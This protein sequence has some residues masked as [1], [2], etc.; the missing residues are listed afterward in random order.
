MERMLNDVEIRILGCLIEKENTTPEY[1]PLS[2][3]ALTNACNQKSNRN[4]V[5][6]FDEATVAD[7]I[8]KLHN[9]GFVLIASGTGQRVRKYLHKCKDK[10]FVNQAGI[11]IMCLLMLRGAQTL[12]ELRTRSERIYSFSSLEE[13]DETIAELTDR[14]YPLVVKL[15]R[16][17]GQ[18]RSILPEKTY[19]VTT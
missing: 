3:N 4:P 13:V 9:E 16:Q 5:V 2:L 6:N 17:P 8:R 1:Y 11:A 19:F 14:D 18:K 15:P 10:F 12:G 7:Y